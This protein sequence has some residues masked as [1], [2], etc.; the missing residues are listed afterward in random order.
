[1][2]NRCTQVLCTAVRLARGNSH[3]IRTWAFCAIYFDTHAF[4][5]YLMHTR[6]YAASDICQSLITFVRERW[7][8]SSIFI[9][10]CRIF[11]CLH[12][13]ITFLYYLK[14]T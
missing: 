11:I 4:V 2:M 1:M 12:I 7:R 8:R 6:R 5:F 13:Y 10:S 3:H 14:L 9:D